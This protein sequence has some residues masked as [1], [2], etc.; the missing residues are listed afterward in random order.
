MGLYINVHHQDSRKIHQYVKRWRA[1]EELLL[2]LSGNLATI[3]ARWAHRSGPLALEFSASQVR[4]L[5]KALFQ[6]T[7]RRAAVLA[8]IE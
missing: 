2:V 1:F 3:E 7:T 6:N 8:S 4:Q 5:I